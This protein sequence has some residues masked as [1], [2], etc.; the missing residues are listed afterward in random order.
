MG[1]CGISIITNGQN[2]GSEKTKGNHLLNTKKHDNTNKEITENEQNNL[3]EFVS[4]KKQ[5]YEKEEDNNNKINIKEKKDKKEQIKINKQNNM[6]KQT[7]INRN[8]NITINKTVPNYNLKSKINSDAIVSKTNIFINNKEQN[9]EENNISFICAYDIKDYNE[10]QIINNIYD[11]K[12][13]EEIKSKVKIL[14]DK[15]K[16]SLVFK[17]K[18]NK[19]GINFLNFIIEGELNNMSFMFNN[20]QS[21]KK[22]IFKS[23]NTRKVT[24]MNELFCG[25]TELE[26]LDLSNF[27]TS[28]VIDMSFMFY[29]CYKLKKSKELI[30]LIQLM[31]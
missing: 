7:I 21:L 4:I 27:N 11:N 30:I 29:K 20:C 19:L 17:K 1:C 22:V 25:C 23:I 26:Y 14:N 15:K 28:N 2:N 3:D 10:A 31:Q 6:N 9:E 5:I 24:K 16:E 12:I 8:N 13:N 18:F